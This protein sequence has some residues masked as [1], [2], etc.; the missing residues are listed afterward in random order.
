MGILTER[1]VFDFNRIM[2]SGERHIEYSVTDICNRNCRSCSHLAPLAKN[3]NF[4]CA[5]EF[6]KT[7]LILQTRLPDVHTFWLTGGEP[8]LHPEFLRLLEILGVIYAGSFIGIYTNGSTLNKYEADEGFWEFM[9]KTGVVWAV[10][11][12]D[13]PKEYFEKL[14]ERKSCLNNLTFVQR[15]TKFTNLTNYSQNRA[16]SREKYERCGWERLKLNVRNGKIYNCPSAE[17]ADLFN[18]YFGE[19]LKI[20]KEDYLVIDE[21]LTSEAIENFRGPVPF[22][23]QCDLSGRYTKLFDNQPSKRSIEEWAEI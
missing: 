15:G 22:C 9:R 16:V 17:Y 4:I 18:G 19:R 10:T 2:Q 14:F 20:C 13:K 3:P 12:Y 6:E 21:K 23:S 11:P 8:T 7:V 1:Y 5:E